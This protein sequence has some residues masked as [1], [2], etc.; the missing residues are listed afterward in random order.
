LQ[1][2]LD[3]LVRWRVNTSPMPQQSLSYFRLGLNSCFIYDPVMTS[4]SS[5]YIGTS[6]DD[7]LNPL[8]VSGI[9]EKESAPGREAVIREKIYFTVNLQTAA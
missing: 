8:N 9:Y 5:I 3:A 7:H 1:W 4:R 6:I 2:A